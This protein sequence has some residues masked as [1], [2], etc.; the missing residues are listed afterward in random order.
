MINNNKTTKLLGILE[1]K[2]DWWHN[3]T[4]VHLPDAQQSQSLRY[5]VCSKEMLY[6]RGSQMRQRASL[7]STSLKGTEQVLCNYRSWDYTYIDLKRQGNLG[8]FIRKDGSCSLSKHIYNIYPMFTLGWILNVRT[9]PPQAL[10]LGDYLK[11]R[12]R[13]DGYALRAGIN[14]ME[15]GAHYFG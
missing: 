10:T 9:R 3:R 1:V 14:W 13:A 4:Q 2:L 11:T 5:Q 15:F 7:I 12:R 6:L 8:L